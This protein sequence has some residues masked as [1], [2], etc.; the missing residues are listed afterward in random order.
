MFSAAAPI[1]PPQSMLLYNVN[2]T[3]ATL[4]MDAWETGG[5]TITSFYVDLQVMGDHI[6]KNVQRN[7]S[8]NV[9]RI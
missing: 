5:C 3:S 9:V 7:I 6:W 2:M 4:A 1:M 8:P